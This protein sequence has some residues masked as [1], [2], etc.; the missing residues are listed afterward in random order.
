MKTRA[1]EAFLQVVQA[2]VSFVQRRAGIVLFLCLALT[3]SLLGYTIKTIGINTDTTN[4]LSEE[5][6]FRRLYEEHKAAFPHLSGTILVLVEAP[7]PDLSREAAARLSKALQAEPETFTAVFY[8]VGD[9]FFKQNGLLYLDDKEL[10]DLIFRLEASAPF[11][12][13]LSHNPTLRGLTGVIGL[14]LEEATRDPEGD[15]ART[16]AVAKM[17]DRLSQ[18][19]ESQKDGSGY[20]IDWGQMMGDVSLETNRQLILVQPKRDYSTLQPGGAAIKRIHALADQLGLVAENGVSVRLTGSTALA[21]EELKSVESNIGMVGLLSFLLVTLVLSFGLRS[22]RLVVALLVTLVMG[23]IWTGGFAALAIGSL[24]LISVAF[25]VLFIGLGVDF[26]VHFTLRYREEVERG[27]DSHAG[28]QR[29]SWRMASPLGLCMLSTMIAFLSFMPTSYQGLSELGIISGAGMMIALIATFTVTPALLTLLPLK[30]RQ[31]VPDQEQ[32]R[33]ARVRKM[34]HFVTWPTRQAKPITL[35]GLVL[36]L[37]GLALMPSLRFDF[38]PMNLRDPESESV[39]AFREMQENPRTDPYHGV[40]MMPSLAE[41]NALAER[42]EALDVVGR[43]VTLSDFVPKNQEDK[44]FLIEDTALFMREVLLDPSPKAEDDRD[45]RVRREALQALHSRLE[46]LIAS[47]PEGKQKG[48]LYQAAEGLHKSITAFFAADPDDSALNQLAARIVGGL[49]PRLQDL[50][51]SLTA[52]P[53]SAADLPAT[54]HNRMLAPD[55]RAR[56]EIFPAA[57][58]KT[59]EDLARFVTE[60]QAIAPGLTGTPAIIYAAADA[61]QAAVMTA[62]AI[63][64]VLILIL[65]LVLLHSLLEAVLVLIPLGLAG[66]MTV[67]VCVLFDLPL[68]F[69]NVI[70]VPLLIGLGVDSGIHIVSRVRHEEETE[71]KVEELLASSTPRAVLISALTT[72]GSFGTLALSSHRGTA[73]MGELLA[74]AVALTLVCTLIILPALLALIQKRRR[75]PPGAA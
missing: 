31:A 38:D 6:E 55:G 10:E 7:T 16:E 58:L 65:L 2:W 18:A 48:A 20:R 17:L 11:L 51:T 3:G 30:P 14:V 62:L 50:R 52:T 5:L 9:P 4:M 64:L 1:G 32:A 56:V 74:I 28:L 34:A 29:A 15:A 22:V 59:N 47:A 36:A 42:L 43:A 13:A 45:P 67:G 37:I 19:I 25:A 27:G 40:V 54:L 49:E 21:N 26:G 35:I 63:A 41:A 8:A 71:A 60:V 69:A 70:V 24:N 73:S 61:V 66:V 39:I 12:G 68:N 75:S 23:L 44:L 46:D 57:P 72:I 33:Q 53:V